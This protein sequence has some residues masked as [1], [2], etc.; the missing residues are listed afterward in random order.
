MLWHNEIKYGAVPVGH[1]TALKEQRDDTRT[2]MDLLEYH[3]QCWVK[4]VDLKMA[5]FLLSQQRDYT[6]FPCFLCMWDDS[7]DRENHWNRKRWPE[8][9]TLKAG[10]PNV[11][12]DPIV[13]RDKI[14]FPLF[15]IKLGLTK[16][17]VKAL[18][19]DGEGFQ[20]LLHKFPGL[21]YEKIKAEVFDG[22]QIRALQRDQAF[23]Q[24]M[25]DKEKVARL[26]FVN[27]M[28]NFFAHK[29][30]G[31]HKDLIGNMLSAFHDLGCK[32]SIKVHCLFSHLDK[33]PDNLGAVSDEQEER[34]Y[35]KDLM[36]V[37]E[38]YQ[39]G[40]I[41]H[42]LAD[43]SWSTKRDCP[44]IMYKRKSYKPQYLTGYRCLYL[45]KL[46]VHGYGLIVYSFRQ[47]R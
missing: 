17:L 31:I 4:C 40:R 37:E 44:G 20:Y 14:I 33:F 7:R 3:E 41:R 36:A 11:V 9:D 39:G 43:Y 38:R 25:N 26:S 10:M 23:V 15:H 27:V 45:N 30:A 34:F 19:L 16:Q 6:K 5:S 35:Q 12:Y 22:P 32:M 42:M 29:K 46:F 13:S 24:T 47:W 28:K 21:S 2:V 18:R 8:R 1:S